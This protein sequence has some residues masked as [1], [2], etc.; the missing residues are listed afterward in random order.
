MSSQYTNTRHRRQVHA[1]NAVEMPS[2]VEL[3]LVAEQL[4]AAHL[5]RSERLCFL[6]YTAIKSFELLLNLSIAG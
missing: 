1:E 5:R 3:G 6:V 2:Q 4:L